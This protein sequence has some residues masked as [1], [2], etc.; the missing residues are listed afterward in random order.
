LGFSFDKPDFMTFWIE[1]KRN[2]VTQTIGDDPLES[3][4]KESPS[5]VSL[6]ITNIERFGQHV[7][8]IMSQL[9]KS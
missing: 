3:S 4:V 9:R 6:P 1:N 5:H 2:T 8:F 7:R